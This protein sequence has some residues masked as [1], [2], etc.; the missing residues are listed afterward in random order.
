M[1]AV[2]FLDLGINLRV[3]VLVGAAR[4]SRSDSEESMEEDYVGYLP[5]CA[6]KFHCFSE[7]PLQ[8]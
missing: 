7:F 6:L 8:S 2:M 4:S 5:H 3:D 1:T